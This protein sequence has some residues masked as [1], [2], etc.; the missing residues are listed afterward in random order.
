MKNT[1]GIL[2]PFVIVLL[3]CGTALS[4]PRFASRTGARCQSCHENPSGAGMRREFGVTYGRETLPVPAWSDEFN[5]DGFSPRLSEF[6]SLGADFRTL[7]YY[8]QRPD[9]GVPPRA[10]DSKNAFWQMQGDIDVNLRLAKRVSM[11]LSKGLYTDGGG[12]FEIF[13]LL[14]LLPANG[15]LKIG[16]FVPN[17]GTKIDDHR[18]FI[19]DKT[20]FSPERGRIELTGA[21]AGVSP[22]PLTI[23]GGL[24]NAADGYGDGTGND[25]A[26]LG[27][28]EGMFKLAENVNLG[29]GGNIFTRKVAGVTTTLYGGLGSFSYGDLTV[30]GEVDVIKGNR[31]SGVY[32]IVTYVETDYVVTPGLDMKL[33]YDFYDPDKDTKTGSFAR[34][35]VGFG[36]FPI[37]GVEVTPVYRLLRESSD[38]VKNDEFHLMIHFYW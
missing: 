33:A 27:R 28:A 14:N 24:Y 20:G 35:S 18:A 3:A 9:T 12:G 19:R 22:G 1:R 11:Y 29:L 30:F 21:E 23:T 10:Q 25:K 5:L 15:F 7:F 38:E 6:I 36:F 26:F 34:Y 31:T 13:G 32:G 2:V 16:R 37:S 4:M 17:Y 8:I